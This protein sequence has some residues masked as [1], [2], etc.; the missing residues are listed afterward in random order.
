MCSR[1]VVECRLRRQRATGSKDSGWDSRA[2]FWGGGW[3]ISHD[4]DFNFYPTF[5][6]RSHAWNMSVAW[7]PRIASLAW[8]CSEMPVHGRLVESS[9]LAQGPLS[10]G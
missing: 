8:M 1:D 5:V 10:V 2:R 3:A 4:N 7:R 6:D 9:H